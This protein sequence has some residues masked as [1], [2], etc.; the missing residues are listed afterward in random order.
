MPDRRQRT[1]TRCRS[2]VASGIGSRG[3]GETRTPD[4]LRVMQAFCLAE[5]R[6]HSYIVAADAPFL[7]QLLQFLPRLLNGVTVVAVLVHLAQLT[8]AGVVDPLTHDGSSSARS[9]WPAS[10]QPFPCERLASPSLP[11][12]LP[13]FE[14]MTCQS[15]SLRYFH[16]LVKRHSSTHV[17]GSTNC[18]SRWPDGCMVVPVSFELTTSRFSGERSHQLSYGTVEPLSGVEPE[19]QPYK[20]CVL[21]IDTTAAY[22]SGPAHDE[23]NPI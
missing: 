1:C 2:D 9:S 8:A 5:L 21:A 4:F 14:Q 17:R 7:A 18:F 19:L 13:Q 6:V 11:R 20:G 16:R 10:A 23:P 12:S 15:N 22:D 3:R